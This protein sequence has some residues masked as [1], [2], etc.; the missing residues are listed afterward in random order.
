MDNYEQ[1][2]AEVAKLEIAVKGLEKQVKSYLFWRRM[3]IIIG[4]IVGGVVGTVL[5][6]LLLS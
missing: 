5:M 3:G 2:Q 4:G 1:L 6:R